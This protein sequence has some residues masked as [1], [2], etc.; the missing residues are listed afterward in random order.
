MSFIHMLTLTQVVGCI[1]HQCNLFTV[2]FTVN[3]NVTL[4]GVQ[5]CIRMS[6]P[7]QYVEL[8]DCITI[9]KLDRNAIYRGDDIIFISLLTNSVC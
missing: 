8:Y 6:Q 1:S 2:R 5:S 7:L 4:V 9:S 3:T